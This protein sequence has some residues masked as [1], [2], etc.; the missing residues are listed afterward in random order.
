MG[1]R[2]GVKYECNG[3]KQETTCNTCGIKGHL[4]RGCF[5]CYECNQKGHKSDKCFKNKNNN[6]QQRPSNS[7]EGNNTLRQQKPTSKLAL[8]IG[9]KCSDHNHI[10]VFDSG[11]MGHMSKRRDWCTTLKEWCTTR[12]S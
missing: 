12:N 9:V 4:K 8:I 10:W 11:A 1:L 5:I 2:Q 7:K 3:A 6:S